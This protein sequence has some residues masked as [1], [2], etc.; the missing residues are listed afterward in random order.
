MGKKQRK[1]IT[2]NMKS[3]AAPFG[4]LY[5]IFDDGDGGFEQFPVI[6]FAIFDVSD[7][8]DD[9]GGLIS[10][11][12]GFWVA[13]H[14]ENFIGYKYEDQENDEFLEDHGHEPNKRRDR[15]DDDDE[16]D[17]DDDD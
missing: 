15:D 8:D 2:V 6:M 1:K 7:D 9:I 16:G 12:D 14:D 5:A 17:D 10:G 11:P 4:K 13:D 3:L